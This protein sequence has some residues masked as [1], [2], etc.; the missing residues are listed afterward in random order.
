MYFVAGCLTCWSSHSSC[1]HDTLRRT[2][3]RRMWSFR[4]SCTCL[5]VCWFGLL[6]MQVPIS[7]MYWWFDW[8][9]WDLMPKCWLAWFKV[10]PRIWSRTRALCRYCY[11][12]QCGHWAVWRWVW[13]LWRRCCGLRGKGFSFEFICIRFDGLIHLL[14]SRII[15]NLM[16][17]H[18][19]I[20]KKSIKQYTQ[21]RP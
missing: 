12:G 11:Q 13:G 21:N 15:Y 1:R 6:C 17:T 9:V 10:W 8:W 14:G 4:S 20:S 3:D 7:G 19:S 5:W 16:F 2:W 18:L